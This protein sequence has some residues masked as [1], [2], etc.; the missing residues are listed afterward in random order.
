VGRHAREK[1]P[2]ASTGEEEQGEEEVMSDQLKVGDRVRIS[3]RSHVRGYQP[4]D[5]GI[6]LEGPTSYTGDNQPSYVVAMDKDGPGHTSIIFG[7]DEIEPI[8]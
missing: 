4:G 5:K 7:A 2:G 8:A 1:L 6:V 3:Q